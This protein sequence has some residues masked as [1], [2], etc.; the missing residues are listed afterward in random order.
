METEHTYRVEVFVESCP[1]WLNR[2]DPISKLGKY[3]VYYT[4]TGS[5]KLC[6]EVRR[7]CEARRVR[8]RMFDMCWER[9]DDYR[10]KFLNQFPPTKTEFRCAYCGKYLT[11]KTLVV[12]HLVPVNQVKKSQKARKLLLRDGITNVNDLRNLVASCETCNKIKSDQLGS[13]YT[14]GKLGRDEFMQGI[15]TVF[16]VA[17]FV[18]AVIGAVALLAYL[19]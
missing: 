9:S 11:R 5:Y 15:Y 18:G 1:S 2:Y 16:S 17:V 14:R 7:A 19:F 6:A 3:G 8:C 12:D 4:V 10:Q 13:W